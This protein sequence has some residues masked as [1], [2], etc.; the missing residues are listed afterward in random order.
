M[1]QFRWF[2]LGF[3]ITV[4]TACNPVAVKDKLTCEIPAFNQSNLSKSDNLNVGIYVDGSGSMLG[5]VRDGKTN[6]VKA[7]NSIRNAFELIGKLPVEYYRLDNPNQK[8]TGG[9]YYSYAGAPVFYDGSNTKFKAVSSPI[10]AAIIPPKKDEERMTV[11][12]TDLEQNSGDVTRLT[13][14]IQDIYFNLDRKDYAVGIWAIKSEFNG[15]VYVQELNKLKTF[16]YSSGK[17]PEKFRPFY[18]LF[19]GPYRDIQYYFDYLKKNDSQQLMVN[20]NLMIFHPENIINGVSSLETLPTITVPGVNRPVSLVKNGVSVTKDNYPGELLQIDNRQEESLTI[21][22]TL[23]FYAAK[24][25]LLIDTDKSLINS[26]VDVEKFDEFEK[27]FKVM[28]SSDINTAFQLQDWQIQE[29]KLNFSALI[30]PNK[31]PE[32]GVYKFKFDIFAQRLQTPIWWKE[33]DWEARSNEQDG[34]KTQGI[35][36]FFIGLK[37]RTEILQSGKSNNSEDNNWLIGRLCY[38]IQKN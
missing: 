33:W 15:T 9:E 24:Y 5:Y 34:T 28:N 14:K 29:N 19:V 25:S 27:K 32:S 37:N 12:V 6:Y 16:A 22:Y 4:L 10:D 31:F 17:E 26:K 2:F 20:S 13:K 18:V 7:L 23:P 3:V 21:N 38:G 36:E 11:I 8:I 35:E 1:M 30:E